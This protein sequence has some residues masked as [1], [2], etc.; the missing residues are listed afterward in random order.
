MKSILLVLALIINTVVF[1]QDWT[2]YHNKDFNFSV[3]LPGEPKTME[4]EVPTEVGDLT[5][6]MFMVD[7]SV[8]EGSSNLMYMVIHTEYPVN[9]R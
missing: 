5:M 4:Q 2:T 9:P 8:Y 7:A 1:S 6:R 3:D